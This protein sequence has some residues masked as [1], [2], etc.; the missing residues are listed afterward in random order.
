[1]VAS[2]GLAAM[3][4]EPAANE[5]AVVASELGADLSAH[6]SRPATPDLLAQADD[7]VGM[8]AGH[9]HGLA[10]YLGTGS[11]SRLLCGESDLADP[12]GGD[13]TVYQACAGTIWQHLQRLVD[14]LLEQ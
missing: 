6:V 10:G 11:R 7:V 9:M 13:R 14:E 1:V 8:T 3:R 5:A 2:A 12:I 4:G